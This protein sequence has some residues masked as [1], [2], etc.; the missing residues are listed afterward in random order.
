MAAPASAARTCGC[1]SDATRTNI[2]LNGVPFNDAES[3]GAFLVSL[4]RDLAT[5]AEDVEIRRG[6]GPT[7]N[8]RAHSVPA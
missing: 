3:R 4:P 1:Q 8:G 6:V 7:A 2:T 5:G